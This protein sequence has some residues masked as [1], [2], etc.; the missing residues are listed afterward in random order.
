[1]WIEL[2]IVLVASSPATKTHKLK[3]TLCP[4]IPPLVFFSVCGQVLQFTYLC[5]CA[6][7]TEG[8]LEKSC[9]ISLPWSCL[10]E[11]NIWLHF[12]S[13]G[14][15]LCNLLFLFHRLLHPSLYNGPSYAPCIVGWYHNCNKFCLDTT[16]GGGDGSGGKYK[17]ARSP[18]LRPSRL[19]HRSVQPPRL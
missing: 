8:R 16:G 2:C 6:T 11:H 7:L 17:Y 3:E 5:P 13:R 4:P 19:V 9:Y 1:M 15:Q 14:C 12:T 18:F 10:E